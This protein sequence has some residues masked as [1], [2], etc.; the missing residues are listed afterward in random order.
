MNKVLTLFPHRRNRDGLYDSIC[1]RCF[2]TVVRSKPEAEMKVLEMA[3]VCDPS[4]LARQVSLIAADPWRVAVP[5][6]R[7]KQ[8][9][10]GSSARPTASRGS[11]SV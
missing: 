5:A 6:D 7:R 3:H 10:D 1:S 4:S 2:A 11:P 8:Q 9:S